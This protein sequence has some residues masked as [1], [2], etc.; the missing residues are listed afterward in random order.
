MY[1]KLRTSE[2]FDPFSQAPN[3][4][5]YRAALGE[6]STE[7]R[8]QGFVESRIEQGLW[9][10]LASA[11]PNPSQPPFFLFCMAAELGIRYIVYMVNSTLPWSLLRL[12]FRFR[13]SG[14]RGETFCPLSSHLSTDFAM[15]CWE[16]GS[17]CEKLCDGEYHR[18]KPTWRPYALGDA[19]CM[20]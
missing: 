3:Q 5:T 20:F 1:P 16:Y 4:R 18:H 8:E 15:G 9:A 19:P 17:N 13:K 11:S 12:G 2:S 7:L 10:Y 14:V 6:S